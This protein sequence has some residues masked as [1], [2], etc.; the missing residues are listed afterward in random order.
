MWPLCFVVP[1]PERSIFFWKTLSSLIIRATVR[2]T[3]PLSVVSRWCSVRQTGLG[4]SYTKA[5]SL[6]ESFFIKLRRWSNLN[7]L[8]Y[9][10]KPVQVFVVDRLY[11]AILRSLEQTHCAHVWFYM[12]DWLF[13]VRFLNIHRSG[14]LT[15]LAWLGPHETAAICAS[16]VY[17]I[18]PCSMSLHA[19]PHT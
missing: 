19:K 17:T 8:G 6:S 1:L 10:H 15:A 2:Q 9:I 7:K 11:S 18:Q 13:I 4:N 14:V 3:I 16:S 5:A 12:S